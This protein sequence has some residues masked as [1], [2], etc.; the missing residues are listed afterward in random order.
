MPRQ[1]LPKELHFLI[2]EAGESSLRRAVWRESDFRENVWCCR[3][4]DVRTVL[5]FRVRLDDSRLLTDPRHAK[6][7][8][9]V[10]VFLCLQTH[11]Y[12]TGCQRLTDKTSRQAVGV[13]IRILDYFFVRASA[14]KLATR[15]FGGVSRHDILRLVAEIGAHRRIKESLYDVQEELVRYLRRPQSAKSNLSGVFPPEISDVDVERE[16]DLSE[17]E[18]RR[19]RRNLWSRGLYEYSSSRDGR[20]FR[21]RSQALLAE[22]YRNRVIGNLKFDNLPLGDLSFGGTNSFPRECHAVPIHPQR[23]ND[24][25]S[26]EYLAQYFKTLR[27]M[28]IAAEHGYRLIDEQAFLVLDD[29]AFLA[30]LNAKRRSRVYTLPFD[31]SSKAF[32]DAL[33]FIISS[34][35]D[36]LQSYLA[37]AAVAVADDVKLSEVESFPEY[38]ARPL[39]RLGVVRWRLPIMDGIDYFKRL[40][41]NEGLYEL[42]LVMFGSVLVVVGTLMA[43]RIEELQS[44]SPASW[45]PSANGWNLKFPLGKANFGSM[46]KVINRPLPN[47]G[48]KALDLLRRLQEGISDL[49]VDVRK[50]PIF[51]VPHATRVGVTSASN[52]QI[53]MCLDRFCDYTQTAKDSKGRRHYIRVH[54]LRRN[55]AMLFFWHFGIGALDILRHFLGHVRPEDVWRYITESTSGTVLQRVKA[56]FAALRIARDPTAAS[57]LVALLKARFGIARISIMPAEDVADYVED[58]IVG[59]DVTVEPEFFTHRNG[60]PRCK[61]LI[62]VSPGG[63]ADEQ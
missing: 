44:L 34:G 42:L 14:F 37:C 33:G 3:F 62:K 28:S 23:E 25:V 32:S 55:F 49:G 18:I 54:Q 24:S 46:H 10:K 2:S 59:G 11:P 7:L 40:R 38:I 15:G 27:S 20:K 53:A 21:V 36:L 45:W 41:R 6:T 57:P 9:S 13:A 47:V 4:G 5:D 22:I 43:R 17:S 56:E 26:E 60:G 30:S 51:A 12:V 19:A 39:R 29:R 16:L 50:K 31:V 61:I 58:L 8:E 63:K 35:E 1:T 48:A 52:K